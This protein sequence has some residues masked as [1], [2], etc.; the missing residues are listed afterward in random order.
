[1]PVISTSDRQRQENL[2][3]SVNLSYIVRSSLKKERRKIQSLVCLTLYFDNGEKIIVYKKLNLFL[4]DRI[5]RKFL[6][7]HVINLY[8]L[9]GI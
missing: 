1:M 7:Y 3:F 9:S 6:L 4:S 8:V 5:K 2:Q